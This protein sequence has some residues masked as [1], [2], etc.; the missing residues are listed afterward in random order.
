M[1]KKTNTPRELTLADL[2]CNRQEVHSISENSTVADAISAIKRKKANCLI[3]YDT[4]GNL[5]GLV[6]EHDIVGAI[7]HG[8]IDSLNESIE[9]YMTLDLI[10]CT[11]EE[12]V[13]S[14]LEMMSESDIRHLPV[15]S[16]SGQLMGFLSILELL[17]AYQKHN[18]KYIASQQ[19]K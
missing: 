1:T 2:V 13:Q 11:P 7:A 4:E 9:G 14:A 19:K 10:V 16:K 18:Q 6:S 8:G 15:V 5:A 12:S 3:V 17:T